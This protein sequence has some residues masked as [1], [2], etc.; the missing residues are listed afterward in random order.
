MPS[1]YFGF[2]ISSINELL[3]SSWPF[4]PVLLCEHSLLAVRAGGVCGGACLCLC[5]WECMWG[6]GYLYFV[7][8]FTIIVYACVCVCVC[9]RARACICAHTS[10]KALMRA[11]AYAWRSKDNFLKL[12]L[13]FHCVGPGNQTQGVRHGQ[14]HL[15]APMC[16]YF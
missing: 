6:W 11:I 10:V 14:N 12:I 16:T 2:N 1:I 3:N 4:F 8:I 15:S 13:S 7:S 9:S 5:K